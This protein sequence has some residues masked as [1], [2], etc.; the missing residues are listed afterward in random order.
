MC[1]QF[2]SSC[3]R[4][5]LLLIV[6]S[7]GLFRHPRSVNAQENVI[8]IE[9]FDSWIFGQMRDESNARVSLKSRIELEIERFERITSLTDPQKAKIRLA[10]TGDMKRFFDQ[11]RR[12]RQKFVEMGAVPQNKINDAYQL[13]S[14]LSQRLSAG[15]FKEGSLLKKVSMSVHDSEQADKIRQYEQQRLERKKKL[16]VNLYLAQLGRSVP[17]TTDQRQRLVKLLCESVE[18]KN[19]QAHYYLM[20]VS[21]RLSEVP[22]TKLHEFLDDNQIKAIEA[23]LRQ[24]ANMKAML[25]QQGVI[26]E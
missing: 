1:S 10:G 22:K 21:Y 24:A 5:L 12:A 16:T 20:L 11:V 19:C 26:D 18:T 23:R 17:L 6:L 15:L 3:V 2:A 8:T 9:Q 4:L 13:A 14:P 7:V 25:V